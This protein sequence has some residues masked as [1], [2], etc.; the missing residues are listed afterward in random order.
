MNGWGNFNISRC[1]RAVTPTSPS[2]AQ[3]SEGNAVGGLVAVVDQLVQDVAED[4]EVYQQAFPDT[5]PVSLPAISARCAAEAPRLSHNPRHQ[6]C[7]QCPN[8]EVTS[9]RSLLGMAKRLLLHGVTS[10]AEARQAVPIWI[11][12]AIILMIP[13]WLSVFGTRN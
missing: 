1:A 11:P 4:A 5:S 12:P 2:M 10:L 6:S 3:P 9:W 13:W 8:S 7:F